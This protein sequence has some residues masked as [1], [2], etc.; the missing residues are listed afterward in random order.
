MALFGREAICLPPLEAVFKYGSGP[1]KEWLKRLGLPKLRQWDPYF[2]AR[3]AA[4][5]YDEEFRKRCPLY[6]FKRLR[7]AAMLGGWHM[8][9][10]EGGWDELTK[11]RRVLW[12]FWNSE[13]WVEVWRGRTGKVQVFQRIT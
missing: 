11:K 1:V 3:K 5:P 10:P 7:T 6:D 2:Q 12:T 13:P 9:W 4:E 8:E